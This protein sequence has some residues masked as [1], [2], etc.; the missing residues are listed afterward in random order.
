MTLQEMNTIIDRVMS[1]ISNE[2]ATSSDIPEVT[3]N[4]KRSIKIRPSSDGFD[5]YVD[6]TQAPYAG[7]VNERRQYW[8][9]VAM[10]VHD[11][12]R[13]ALGAEFTTNYN[14]RGEE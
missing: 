7:Q 1:S 13:A 4:L 6:E 3:G 11:R 12:L 10:M 5:I 8:R 14:P 9:R 2:I